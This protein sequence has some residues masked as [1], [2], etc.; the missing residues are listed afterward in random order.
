MLKHHVRNL[1]HHITVLSD[2]RMR[3]I[4]NNHPVPA[5]KEGHRRPTTPVVNKELVKMNS[6]EVSQAGHFFRRPD[7]NTQML[8]QIPWG[9]S[10]DGV[11]AQIPAKSKCDAL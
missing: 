3:G 2:W 8:C 11:L 7:N 1:V 10:G 4:H 5:I 6:V 9:Q